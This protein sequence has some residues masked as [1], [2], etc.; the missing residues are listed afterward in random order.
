[1]SHRLLF[2]RVHAA[3]SVGRS[4]GLSVCNIFKVLTCVGYFLGGNKLFFKWSM[5]SIKF[6]EEKL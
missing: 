5:S 3:L 6:I 1:M 4:V 2:S